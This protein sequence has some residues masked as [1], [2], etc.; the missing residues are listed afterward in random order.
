M[1]SS[2]DP[3]SQAPT[4]LDCRSNRKQRN[5][6]NKRRAIERKAYSSPIRKSTKYDVRLSYRRDYNMSSPL[7]EKISCVLT[8]ESF[9]AELASST[10]VEA[11]AYG[12]IA[13]NPEGRE[14]YTSKMDQASSIAA[15]EKLV[16]QLATAK[17]DQDLMFAAA[18][19]DQDLMN[20]AQAKINADVDSQLQVLR[21]VGVDITVRSFETYLRDTGRTHNQNLVDAA[22]I[23]AHIPTIE[24]SCLMV[25]DTI[26]LHRYSSVFSE[27]F[28]CCYTDAKELLVVEAWVTLVN[29]RAR[30]VRENGSTAEEKAGDQHI[31]RRIDGLTSSLLQL[32]ASP[33]DI[34]TKALESRGRYHQQYNSMLT[35]ARGRL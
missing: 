10:Q 31:L 5:E 30:L 19:R 22:N 16:N 9:L 3:L 28:G 12:H 18:K 17:R 24:L 6:R 34:R 8:S 23:T 4:S 13:G 11:T 27:L 32:P 29:A 1:S 26:Q 14:L 2:P 33:I 15:L 25:R 20:E 35:E 7:Q 21:P